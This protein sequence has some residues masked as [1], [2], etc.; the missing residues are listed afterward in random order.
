M[1]SRPNDLSISLTTLPPHPLA[2]LAGGVSKHAR[3]IMYRCLRG[4]NLMIAEVCGAMRQWFKPFT[5]KEIA[6]RGICGLGTAERMKKGEPVRFEIILC[7]M[8]EFGDEF[9][10]AL[11][12]PIIGEDKAADLALSARL[13]KLGDELAHLRAELGG[14]ASGKAETVARASIGHNSGSVQVA[15]GEAEAVTVGGITFTRRPLGSL[16]WDGNGSLIEHFNRW[17]SRLGRVEASSA[18]ESAKSDTSGRTGVIV[19]RKGVVTERY[20]APRNRLGTATDRDYLAWCER[21]FTDL[22]QSGE[23]MVLDVDAKVSVEGQIIHSHSRLL[24]LVD[25]AR[26]GSSIISA[27]FE[28]KVAA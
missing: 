8:A 10:A 22:E 25:W 17:R 11:L 7:A 20:I 23:P 13:E 28:E 21:E 9:T 2:G 24:R 3:G 19:R 15:G 16:L 14:R 12:K 18:I 1:G 5:A 26:D 4:Q 6:R 27:R